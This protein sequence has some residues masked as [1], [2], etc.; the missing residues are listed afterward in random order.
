NLARVADPTKLKAEVKIAET[1][2]KDIQ[3]NQR[4]SIDTRNGVVEGHVIRVDPAVE[5]GT[6]KVDVAL[7]GDLPKGA[8]PDLSVDGTIELERL[9][10]VIYVG[11]P[12][13]GQ[14]NNTVGIFKLEAGT[15]EAVRTPVKLGRSSVNT[16]EI[17]S[18]LQPGDQVILSD[19]SAM[20][21][22]E[23]IRLN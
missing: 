21:A 9:D 17:L 6:V 22:H 13:F 5:Q 7:D 4:A 19:T 8:R 11:R 16:I 3:I 1:Q 23:R 10:D 15:S 12:A 18:G 20:D 2:A 14:E